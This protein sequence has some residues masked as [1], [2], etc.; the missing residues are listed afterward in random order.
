M[1]TNIG[2]GPQDIPLNQFLGEMAFI[3][4]PPTKPAFQATLSSNVSHPAGTN[5]LPYNL[6]VYD[7]FGNYNNTTY[8]FTAPVDGLYFFHLNM[9]LY[10]I[11]GKM[12]AAIKVQ[13]SIN[14]SFFG[15][16]INVTSSGDYN[17][18]STAIVFLKA[19]DLVQPF[20][21]NQDNAANLSNSAAWNRFEGYLIY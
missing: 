1:A 18:N 8:T 3:D 11:P 12:L 16:R 20:S 19:G 10:N 15:S 5:I 13:G 17:V 2:T 6:V 9:N 14:M 21:S 4:K 7:K